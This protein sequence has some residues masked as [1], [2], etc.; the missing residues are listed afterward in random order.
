MTGIRLIS[1]GFAMFQARGSFVWLYTS[2]I[3]RGIIVRCKWGGRVGF[4][5]SAKG[6]GLIARRPMRRAIDGGYAI[7]RVMN[8]GGWLFVALY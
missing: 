6:G 8:V 3:V 4:V 5:V 2:C 7:V 1:C